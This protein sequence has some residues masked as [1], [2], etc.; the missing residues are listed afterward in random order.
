MSQHVALFY[1]PPCICDQ[2]SKILSKRYEV[3][4]T[5]HWRTFKRDVV[6]YEVGVV[7]VGDLMEGLVVPKVL[8]FKKNHGFVDI[9]LVGEIIP[10]YPAWLKSLGLIGVLP[11]WGIE[12]HLANLMVYAVG[13]RKDQ[14]FLEIVEHRCPLPSVTTA[15]RIATKSDPPIRTVR[16]LVNAIDITRQ[17]FNNHW[18]RTYGETGGLTPK[19]L[20]DEIILI[21]MLRLRSVAMSWGRI[22]S[23][24]EV[25]TRTIRRICRSSGMPDSARWSPAE[26]NEMESKVYARLCTTLGRQSGS[27]VG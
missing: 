25:P 21:R 11:P 10:P 14:M 13:Q 18:A 19:E 15:V 16:E 5:N 8:E 20:L 9:L 27:T 23:L 1:E 2:V 17:T 6:R 24:L 4:K 3:K 7:V 12:T 26:C 22:S